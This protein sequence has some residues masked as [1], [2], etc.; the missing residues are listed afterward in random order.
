MPHSVVGE[1]NHVPEEAGGHADEVEP[2]PTRAI[3]PEELSQ[4]LD[5]SC[6][7]DNNWDNIPTL[8]T[9][10]TRRKRGQTVAS[11]LI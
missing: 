8:D 7:Q 1:L 5:L 2:M 9:M 11:C 6:Y 4:I 10:S 3:S